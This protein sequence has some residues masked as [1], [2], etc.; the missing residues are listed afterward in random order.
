MSKKVKYTINNLPQNV[1][2]RWRH[3]HAGNTPVEV[4]QSFG[5]ER[6]VICEL[7]D[8]EGGKVIESYHVPIEKNLRKSVVRQIAA[9]KAFKDAHLRHKLGDAA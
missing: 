3:Y 1:Y 4:L 5:V 8:K 9:G 2:P 7:V 6:L